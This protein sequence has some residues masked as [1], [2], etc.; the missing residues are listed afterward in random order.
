MAC[1]EGDVKAKISRFRVAW[2]LQISALM[3]T[4]SDYYSSRMRF[5]VLVDAALVL[6]LNGNQQHKLICSRRDTSLEDY[7]I[8]KTLGASK[9]SLDLFSKILIIKS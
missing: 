1:R 6:I 5:H 3:E 2:T 4:L 8:V 7:F 9:Q